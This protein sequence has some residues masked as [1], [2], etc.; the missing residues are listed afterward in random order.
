MPARSARVI[1]FLIAAMLTGLA[2]ADSDLPR[3]GQLGV[4]LVPAEKGAGVAIESITPGSAAEE[5]GIRA[6]DVV[7]TVDGTKVDTPRELIALI[8]PMPAGRKVEITLQRGGQQVALTVS[9]KERPRDRGTSFEVLYHYVVSGG[10]RI[11]TIVSRPTAPGRHPVLFF[12]PGMGP[13]SLDEPLSGPSAESRILNAF[14]EAG[15]VTVRVE[16]PGIGDSE[17][18]PYTDVD[19]ET[20]LDTYRQALKAVKHYA[21]VD[22]DDVFI[23]GHSIGGVFGPVLAAETPV[24]GVA[25]YGTM[26]KT[27]TEYMLEN[28]RRQ[29][30]LFGNDAVSV[31]VTLRALA[32]GLHRLVVEGQ[33]P[34][35]IAAARPDVGLVLDRFAP[36]GRINGRT[37]RFW[38]QA[39][40]QNLPA[41]WAKGDAS[42]LAIWGNGDFIATEADHPLIADIVNRA[43]PGK[44]AAVV[45]DGVDHGFRKVASMADAF[46]RRGERGEF[47]PQIVTTLKAW[48][49][50]L[51]HR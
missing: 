45:L 14:A 22:P 35:A 49:E 27:F 15:Y 11:R 50:K 33:D 13:V 21:F 10:A 4:R 48:V 5:G 30:R 28:T 39:T 1:S 42:V 40:N 36:G 6:G 41:R 47:D 12:I 38:A 32:D 18:G 20:E 17:G 26:V 34:K 24:K 37:P 25:V 46:R 31:D 16:K 3:R 43:R 23:F 29:A 44:G 2:H 9:L 19:F 51:R 8:A 7:L